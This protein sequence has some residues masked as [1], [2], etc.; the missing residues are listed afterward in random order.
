MGFLAFLSP[1]TLRIYSV[2]LCAFR[3]VFSLVPWVF[4][5]KSSLSLSGVS[6]RS[7]VLFRF[8][9]CVCVNPSSSPLWILHFHCLLW[10]WSFHC[11]YRWPL[12]FSRL[13][14]SGDRYVFFFVSCAD[15]FVG[16]CLCYFCQLFNSFENFS[17][18]FFRFWFLAFWSSICRW[19][20]AFFS[21]L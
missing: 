18:K 17:T 16:Q 6:A 13:P 2:S 4:L 12:P 1:L 15:D 5:I 9:L 8:L 7:F 11:R 20:A 14:L 10:W 3:K 19:N 21:F